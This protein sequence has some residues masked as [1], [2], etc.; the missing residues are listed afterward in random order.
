VAGII[1]SMVLIDALG[2]RGFFIVGFTVAAFLWALFGLVRPISG[3]G[4]CPRR[5]NQRVV[6]HDRHLTTFGP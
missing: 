4:T 6:Q 5:A 3:E 1:F 2:R